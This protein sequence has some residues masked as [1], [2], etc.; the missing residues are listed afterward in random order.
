VSCTVLYIQNRAYNNFIKILVFCGNV[1]NLSFTTSC[2]ST[3]HNKFLTS[4]PPYKSTSLTSQPSLQVNL[5]TYQL[6]NL[7]TFQPSNKTT[8]LTSQPPFKSTSLLPGKKSVTKMLS[9]PILTV[10]NVGCPEPTPDHAPNCVEM[11]LSMIKVRGS[12]GEREK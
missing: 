11:G 3:E 5:L 9:S 12:N 1:W 8:P 10:Y 6:A 4:R 2:T 7:F